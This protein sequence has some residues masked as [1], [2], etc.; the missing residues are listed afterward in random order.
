MQHLLAKAED[1]STSRLAQADRQDAHVLHLLPQIGEARSTGEVIA[2]LHEIVIALGAEAGVF[3]S[4]LRDD[5]TRSSMRSLWACDP[6]WAA[7]YASHRWF[8]CDPW[9]RRASED[10][11]PFRSSDL[12]IKTS[13][14]QAFIES[15]AARGFASAL[16]APAPSLVGQSRVGVLYLGSQTVAILE[17]ARFSHVRVLARALAMELHHWVMKAMREELLQGSNLTE[18]DLNLLSHEAAGHSSK[19]IG[20]ALNLEAKTIDCRFQRLN[21]KLGVPDR[22]TAVR[23]ARLY[24]LL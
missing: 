18:A 23:I 8:E 12:K 22:R 2:L 3:L 21:A 4:C 20:S 6:A 16:I 9:L 5:A 17:G 1:L 24:G 14:D 7:D 11:E 15:A 13:E 10:A 19:V